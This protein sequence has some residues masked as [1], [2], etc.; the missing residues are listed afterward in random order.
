MK[1]KQL[2]LMGLVLIILIFQGMNVA[3]AGL[4]DD[5][6]DKIDRMQREQEQR[7]KMQQER[8]KKEKAE[9]QTKENLKEKPE[10]EKQIEKIA[11]NPE[12]TTEQKMKEINEILKE[13][14]GFIDRWQMKREMDGPYIQRPAREWT[15]AESY[16]IEKEIRKL[17]EAEEALQ[18]LKEGLGEENEHWGWDVYR[19][20]EF[21]RNFQR[22]LP[23]A[24]VSK[25]VNQGPKPKIKIH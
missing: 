5:S 2:A 15:P 11:Q 21:Q 24:R 19:R 7:E 18:K 16:K 13:N 12:K 4:R 9:T 25:C 23:Q 8:E 14:P 17:R 6:F 22:N 3:T 20:L 10:A 1:V